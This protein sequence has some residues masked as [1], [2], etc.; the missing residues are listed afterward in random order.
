MLMIAALS[1]AQPTSEQVKAVLDHYFLGSGAVLA[2]AVLCKTIEKEDE[3]TKWNCIEA[4]GS[5]AAKG[6]TV[7]VHMTFLVPKG[8]TEDLMIQAA[9]DGNVRTTK[10]ITV[11]GSY[12]RHRLFRGFTLHKAGLWE[13]HIR[14]SD[15]VFETLRIE[16]I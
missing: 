11:K 12:F 14:D 15:K 8:Q 9:H 2:E 16:A 13:F 10:D 1:T 5:S 4:Y 7:F 6:D 3:A